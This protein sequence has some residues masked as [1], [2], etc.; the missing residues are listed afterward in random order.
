VD[1]IPTKPELFQLLLTAFSVVGIKLSVERQI[2]LRG[3]IEVEADAII[4]WGLRAIPA[5]RREAFLRR[6]GAA[7]CPAG[8]RNPSRN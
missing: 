5:A 4:A 3:I 7:A 8:A 6:C 2:E 1:H